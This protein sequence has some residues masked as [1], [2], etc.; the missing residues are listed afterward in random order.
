MMI[1]L[2]AIAKCDD[3]GKKDA[4]SARSDGPPFVPSK[5]SFAIVRALPLFRHQPA[6]QQ[7]SDM[8]FC[9]SLTKLPMD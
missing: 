4:P 3:V 8:Q 1:D 5:T 2:P 9:S 7:T 6:L